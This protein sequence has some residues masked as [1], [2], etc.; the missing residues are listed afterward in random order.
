MKKVLVKDIKKGVK[1]WMTGDFWPDGG[2]CVVLKKRF[3]AKE[4]YKG[5]RGDCVLMI[6]LDGEKE[7]LV[8]PSAWLFGEDPCIV[9]VKKP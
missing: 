1:Y 7:F 4:F 5:S 8:S 6:S 2:V 9:T 3:P